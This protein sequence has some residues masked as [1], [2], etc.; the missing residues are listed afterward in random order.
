[1]HNEI[2][3][4]TV[5]GRHYGGDQNWGRRF[6]MRLGGCSTVTACEIALC[7]A[8]S[9]GELRRLYPFDTGNVTRDDF[10]T[11]C[12][13]VFAF[14][15]PG[16]R[17]LTDIRK[18]ADG[19]ARFAGSCGVRLRIRTLDGSC[20]TQAASEFIRENVDAGLPVAYLMLNHKDPRFEDFEWHWFTVTGYRIVHE[21]TELKVATYGRSHL[22]SL[23]DAWN[24]G[25]RWKGG[26]VAAAGETTSAGSLRGRFHDL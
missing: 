14:V 5:D 3:F 19:L 16:L 20:S 23:N 12:E 22:L 17:G 4:I 26:L 7:L 13:E 11:Y 21:D 25:Y 2:E 6:I 9:G 10:I 1:M 24:T 18:Y 8:R 15:H